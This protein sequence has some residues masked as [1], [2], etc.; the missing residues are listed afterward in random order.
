MI[1]ISYAW[2]PWMKNPQ[3]EAERKKEAEKSGRRYA[4][5]WWKSQSISVNDGGSMFFRVIYD[6]KRKQFVWYD[7]NGDA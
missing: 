7:Q 3:I 4:S 2:A 5:D 6:L 1:F